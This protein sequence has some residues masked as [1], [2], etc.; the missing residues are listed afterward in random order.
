MRSSGF[1]Q[2]KLRRGQNLDRSPSIQRDAKELQT[3]KLVS[4]T[5]TVILVSIVKSIFCAEEQTAN[6]ENCCQHC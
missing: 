1:F 2:Y 5:V 6:C 4:R 3:A